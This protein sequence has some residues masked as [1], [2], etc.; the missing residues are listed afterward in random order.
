MSI[1]CDE[2]QVSS[3]S[4]ESDSWEYF[5]RICATET[6]ELIL[7]MDKPFDCCNVRNT[8]EHTSAIKP[9]LAQ[10]ESQNDE[11]FNWL[12][13]E[14]LKYFVDWKENI[15]KRPG[16][17]TANA[18]T[19]MFLSWQTYEGLRITTL[20]LIECVKFLLGVGFSYVLTN[21]LC[22]DD[23]ENYFGKQR[24][25]GHRKDNP[26][27]RDTGYNDNIIKSQFSVRPLGGNVRCHQSNW[28]IDDTLVPKRK[29]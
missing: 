24:A 19:K 4:I 5:K 12:K 17:F 21:K 20:S 14:F 1:F 8:K 16:N 28:D 2:C 3:P 18:R 13:N 6:S 11:R 15:A 22:Q 29:R 7:K 26:N 25:I 23:L 27:V 9:F 10:Y